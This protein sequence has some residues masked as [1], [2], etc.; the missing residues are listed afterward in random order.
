MSFVR[1]VDSMSVCGKLSDMHDAI[2]F[3]FINRGKI[4]GSCADIR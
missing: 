1:D 2:A 4:S 3:I